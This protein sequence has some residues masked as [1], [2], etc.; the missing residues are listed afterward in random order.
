M[1]SCLEPW[2]GLISG[3]PIQEGDDVTIGCGARY[4]WLTFLVQY[5]PVVT[6]NSSVEFM[7]APET[8]MSRVPNLPDASPSGPSPEEMMTTYTIPSV[9][10]GQ[11]LEYTCKV[12]F[13]F[14]GRGYSARNDY[15]N[16][17]LTWS[18]CTV[19]ETVSCKS[20]PSIT[21]SSAKAERPRELDRRL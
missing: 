1:C 20:I 2:C 12:Q 7:E 8:F 9:T 17:T 11:Q 5:N 10:A 3:C 13:K 21:S 6:L 4:N 16:N 19:R 18:A 14:T 15:A